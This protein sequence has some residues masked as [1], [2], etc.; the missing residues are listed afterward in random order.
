MNS[1]VTKTL[2]PK[3]FK[4]ISSTY[5]DGGKAQDIWVIDKIEISGKQL[6]G[7]VRMQS[8]YTSKTDGHTFHMSTIT[9][10]EIVGQLRIIYLHDYLGLTEKTKE[11]WFLKGSERCIKPIRD[12]ASIRV[13]M[14]C[15]VH[16]ISDQGHIVNMKAKITDEKGGDFQYT[17]MVLMK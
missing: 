14:E 9:G 16:F 1:S 7:Y 17:A 15:S 2:Y 12:H 11:I 10:L 8:Y 6:I 4:P 5:L 13:L 3:D